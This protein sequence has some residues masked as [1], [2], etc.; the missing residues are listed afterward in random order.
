MRTARNICDTLRVPK[1]CGGPAVPIRPFLD[2]EVFEQEHI[3]AM[4]KALADACQELGL[5]DKENAAVRLLAKRIIDC[6]RGGIHDPALL[7]AAA[8]KGLGPARRD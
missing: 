5:K 1:L 4:S 6:A 2:G 7:K 3:D 8:T